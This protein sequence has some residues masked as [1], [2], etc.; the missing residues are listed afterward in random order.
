M[1][2]LNGRDGK[3]TFW[4]AVCQIIFMGVEQAEWANV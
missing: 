4:H 2:A 1:E 3:E